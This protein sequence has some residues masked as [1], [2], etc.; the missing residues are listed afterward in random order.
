MVDLLIILQNA[1]GVEEGYVPSYEHMGFANSQT[2]KRLK[3]IIPEDTEYVIV[4]SSPIIG[5]NP[6]SCF[7]AD[8]K[9]L[10]NAINHFEPKLIVCCGKIAQKGITNLSFILTPILFMPHPAYRALSKETTS[11]IKRKIELLLNENR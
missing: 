10:I 2:G 7:A 8:P 4:N 3:E 11:D 5:D 1:Y 9:Y 6:D